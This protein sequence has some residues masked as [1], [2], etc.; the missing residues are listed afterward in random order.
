MVDPGSRTANAVAK[1]AVLQQTALAIAPQNV[2]ASNE[3]GVLLAEHG[4]LD[5]AEKMFRQCVATNATPEAWRNLAVVY[6]RKGDQ[7]SSRSARASGDA[8]AKAGPAATK[9]V[10]TDSLAGAT[11][12]S[13]PVTQTQFVKSDSATNQSNSGSDGTSDSTNPQSKPSLMERI[14][15][16]SMLPSIMRR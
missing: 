10:G 9:P 6:A 8:L 16:S 12:T 13:A 5:E 3:L 1:A 15:L 4:Q 2:L 14:N 11:W 7:A